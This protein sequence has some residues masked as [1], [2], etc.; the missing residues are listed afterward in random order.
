MKRLLFIRVLLFLA[1]G[2]AFAQGNNNRYDFDQQDLQK[3]F[4]SQGIEVFKF[5][6]DLKPG[7]YVSISYDEYENG[8]LTKRVDVLED[9]YLTAGFDMSPYYISQK[10]T[11][12]FYRFYFLNQADS[13]MSINMI[14][15]GMEA[16]GKFDI[17]KVKLGGFNAYCGGI[18]D[19]KIRQ[20][21]LSCIIIRST[22]AATTGTPRTERF[23][24]RTGFRSGN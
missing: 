16:G 12:T 20:G 15:P 13:V 21:N 9:I 17:S 4:K 23:F 8:R 14:M 7:E 6:F 2:L 22:R 5:P 10:D 18:V 1:P 11:S 24:V 3:I 19:E